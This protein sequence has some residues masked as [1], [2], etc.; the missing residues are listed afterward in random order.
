MYLDIGF[1]TLVQSMPQNAAVLKD[2]HLK[3]FKKYGAYEYQSIKQ[4]FSHK[5]VR[6]KAYSYAPHFNEAGC[7]PS[8]S[9]GALFNDALP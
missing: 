7:F 3:D 5:K 6:M 8:F 2:I 1:C 4:W 9:S